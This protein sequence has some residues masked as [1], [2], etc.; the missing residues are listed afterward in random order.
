MHVERAQYEVDLAR[1]R[2]MQIDPSRRLA[3]NT[4]ATNWNDKLRA[5]EVAREEYDRGREADKAR[6]V[7]QQ[8][9]RILQLASDFP[10]LWCDPS[11]SHLESKRMTALIIEDVTLARC[12]KQFSLG[13]CE[14][15]GQG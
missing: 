10:N 4:L 15:V 13:V 5:L 11:T 7:D 1:Q 12:D 8:R 3:A 6:L 14:S 2:Y 9:K